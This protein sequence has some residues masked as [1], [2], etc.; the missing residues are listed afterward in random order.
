M[1]ELP[2]GIKL[3]FRDLQEARKTS[4]RL[5][6][7]PPRKEAKGKRPGAD[8]HLP[9]FEVVANKDPELGFLRVCEL[10]SRV[11]FAN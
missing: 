8:A 10:K 2:G 4:K 11:G 1:W 9:G 3:E 5:D 7:S 6:W